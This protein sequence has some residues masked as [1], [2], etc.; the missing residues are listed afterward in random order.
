MPEEYC[1][2]V[3]PCVFRAGQGPVDSLVARLIP[4][5]MTSAVILA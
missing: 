1:G 4:L 2:T 3:V 5:K